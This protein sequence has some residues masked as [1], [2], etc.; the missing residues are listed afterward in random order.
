[1]HWADELSREFLKQLAAR[2]AGLPVLAVATA[3]PEGL[4]GLPVDA[5]GVESLRLN[6]LD[7]SVAR[8]LLRSHVRLEPPDE[9]LESLIV[10]KSG[11]NRL[12]LGWVAQSLIEAT[13]LRRLPSGAYK[14]ASRIEDIAIPDRLHD[15]LLSRIDRLSADEKIVLKTAA[16]VGERFSEDA[17]A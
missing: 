2:I 6:R 3:R 13:H 14:R 16:V 8:D 9:A 17:V 1:V 7:A 10:E 12:F 11:G 5:A 4:D 15:L